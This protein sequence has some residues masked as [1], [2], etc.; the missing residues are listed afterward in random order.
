MTLFLHSLGAS[1]STQNPFP[2]TRLRIDCIEATSLDDSCF[3]LADSLACSDLKISC[4]ITDT[5]SSR[6][7]EV[8]ASKCHCLLSSETM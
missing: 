8:A 3:T 1:Q 7:S 6:S 2:G 4:S 5:H